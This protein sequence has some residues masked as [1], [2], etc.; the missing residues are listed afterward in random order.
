MEADGQKGTTN[1][2]TLKDHLDKLAAGIAARQDANN[3][4]GW[5]QLLNKDGKFVSQQYNGTTKMMPIILKL[6]QQHCFLQLS[7]RLF[8]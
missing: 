7:L 8:A 3:T 1:Y 2:T 4:G 5:F 6:Q